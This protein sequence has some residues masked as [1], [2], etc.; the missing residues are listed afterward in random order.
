MV[1]CRRCGGGRASGGLNY[2]HSVDAP[3][4][5]KSVSAVK[6]HE[7]SVLLKTVSTMTFVIDK[8]E[9]QIAKLEQRIEEL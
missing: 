1:A 7:L 5:T 4:V 9:Q 2:G 8:L 3:T 6:G